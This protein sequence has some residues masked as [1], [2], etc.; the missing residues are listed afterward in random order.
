MAARVRGGGD[1]IAF[2]VVVGKPAELELLPQVEVAQFDFR[3]EPDVAGE[4]ADNRRIRQRVQ[5]AQQFPNS[6]ANLGLAADE[7]LVEPENIILEEALKI[8]RRGGNVVMFEKFAD[9]A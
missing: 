5:V 3:A 9:E 1:Q 4:Q 6:G 7:N 8:F 2:L